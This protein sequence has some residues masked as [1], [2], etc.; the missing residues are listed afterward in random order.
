M[1]RAAMAGGRR[2]A[3]KGRIHDAEHS[4]HTTF[5]EMR[6]LLYDT[7][8]PSADKLAER[9]EKRTSHTAKQAPDVLGP[10]PTHPPDPSGLPPAVGR[11]MQAMGIALGSLFGSS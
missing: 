2:L 11:V 6:S 3:A 10:P 4:V 8:G 5:D 1:R 7:S 9:F